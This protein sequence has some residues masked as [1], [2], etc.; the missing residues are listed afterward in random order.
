MWIQIRKK[1]ADPGGSG[2]GSATLVFR[3][4]LG[5]GGTLSPSGLEPRP[6]TR[7]TR[8]VM[9]SA[10]EGTLIGVGSAGVQIS[11][12]IPIYYDLRFH[13]N[14]KPPKHVLPGFLRAPNKG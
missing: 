10:Y 14:P 11:T 1:N 6:V 4:Q 12:N 8:W 5:G 3:V 2:S 13:S 9:F 7:F